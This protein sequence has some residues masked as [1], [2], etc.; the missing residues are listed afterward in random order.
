MEKERKKEWKG[1]ESKKMKALIRGLLELV[2]LPIVLAV[3]VFDC[4]RVIGDDTLDDWWSSKVH[5]RIR[6]KID[7]LI[8]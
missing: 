1:D 5:A 2:C 7:K 3:G 4:I 8:R 6:A